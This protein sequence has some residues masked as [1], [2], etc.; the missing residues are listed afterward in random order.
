MN[1][2]IILFLNKKD[3]FLQKIAKYPLT[4]AFEDY[5]E[6]LVIDSI[7]SDARGEEEKQLKEFGGKYVAGMAFILDK[8][9]VEDK[10]EGRSVYSHQTCATDT[11]NIRFVWNVVQDIFLSKVM[12]TQGFWSRITFFS[13]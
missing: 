11:E 12:A 6:Q 13:Q 5:E 9:T 4:V 10:A 7:Q 3:L 2:S 1:T 8:F